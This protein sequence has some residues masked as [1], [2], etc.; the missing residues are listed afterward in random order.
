MKCKECGVDIENGGGFCQ[1]C[2]STIIMPDETA[3]KKPDFVGKMEK[4]VY[5]KIARGF[6]WLALFA[7]VIYLIITLV[8][9]IPSVL[10]LYGGSTSVTQDE[11]QR[12]MNAE[13]MKRQNVPN[14]SQGDKFDPKLMA[15]LDQAIY[16]IVALFSQDFQRKE[17]GVEGL[18]NGIKNHLGQWAQVAEKIMVAQ[19]AKSVIS[20]FPEM[21]RPNAFVQFISLK[22]NKE[23]VRKEKQAKAATELAV[24]PLKLLTI[25]SVITLV[26]MIL[27]LLAIERNTR[28]NVGG[29]NDL[30]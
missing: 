15:Q 6:A 27:V 1:E 10:S 23:F 2:G 7:A 26:S 21:E 22:T 16:E 20:S 3:E 4:S 19:E 24:L 18:R 29:K 5:F 14:M 8:N 28:S 9:F 11:I 12:A 17:G 25:I 13:K 30:Q